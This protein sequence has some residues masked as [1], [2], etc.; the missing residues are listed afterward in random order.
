MCWRPRGLSTL[1]CPVQFNWQRECP[2]GIKNTT[3][4]DTA[5]DPLRQQELVILRAE[6][7]HHQPEDMQE[8]S[9]EQRISRTMHVADFT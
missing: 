5:A 3:S 8:R 7:G 2:T 9:N 4:S 1:A 6:R